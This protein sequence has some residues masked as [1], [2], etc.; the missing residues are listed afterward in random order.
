MKPWAKWMINQNL[1]Y[2][3]L[4]LWGL[5]NLTI[6]IPITVLIAFLEGVHSFFTCLYKDIKYEFTEIMNY[7]K[8]TK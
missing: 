5:I 8:E 1:R 3:L 4:L 6:V 2:L 7:K